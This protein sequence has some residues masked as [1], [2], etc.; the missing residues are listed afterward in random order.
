MRVRIR[1]VVQAS[2][3]ARTNPYVNVASAC[4]QFVCTQFR[5]YGLHHAIV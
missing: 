4:K 2:A 3:L 1:S 5:T